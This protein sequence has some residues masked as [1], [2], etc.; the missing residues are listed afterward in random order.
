MWVFPKIKPTKELPLYLFKILEINI[1]KLDFNFNWFYK[2]SNLP[3][4]E[5][6]NYSESF[7]FPM[8]NK[9]LKLVILKHFPLIFIILHTKSK[10]LDQDNKQILCQKAMDI[11]IWPVIS[12]LKSAGKLN[13]MSYLLQLW[14]LLKK[15]D[16]T[17]DKHIFSPR[18]FPCFQ[19]VLGKAAA[20]VCCL[21]QKSKL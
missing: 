11:N 21:V 6:N 8:N 19:I 15:T 20:S 2:E 18:K 3:Q 5:M 14:R 13:F 4:C 17:F 7:T 1:M 9:I 16:L 10:Q 12:G